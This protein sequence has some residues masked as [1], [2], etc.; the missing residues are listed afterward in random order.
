MQNLIIISKH[1]LSNE[2]DKLELIILIWN[3]I[4]VADL[5]ENVR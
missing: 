5:L 3:Q 2:G 4:L 1:T